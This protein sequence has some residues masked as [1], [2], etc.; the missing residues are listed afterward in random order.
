VT[1]DEEE[2]EEEEETTPICRDANVR[3]LPLKSIGWL[4]DGVPLLN[5]S[6][7][8]MKMNINLHFIVQ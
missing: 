2:E 1:R 8:S 3:E 5:V 6:I 7:V 4:A